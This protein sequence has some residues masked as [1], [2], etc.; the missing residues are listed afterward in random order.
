VNLKVALLLGVASASFPALAKADQVAAAEHQAAMV[1]EVIV[2]AQ[3]RAQSLLEVPAAISAVSAQALENQGIRSV[4]DIGQ[5]VPGLVV[6][7]N[8]GGTQAAIRGVTT[9]VT[10][11]GSDANVAIYVDGV[12]QAL[13]Q[14]NNF[15]FPDLERVEVLK[16]PQG[17]LYG[18]NATGGAILFVTLG[19]QFT[20]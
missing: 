17:S 4:L 5:S 1:G 20:A 15:R 6:D 8:G 18:R 7:R 9:Q 2:T 10:G 3:R 12:Y 11:A 16:G 14:A 19:P 13:T